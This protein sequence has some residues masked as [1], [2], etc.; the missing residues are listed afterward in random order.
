MRKNLLA[1]I[2]LLLTFIL[3]LFVFGELCVNM[4]VSYYI[5][6]S[7]DFLENGYVGIIILTIFCLLMVFISHKLLNVD[8]CENKW[9]KI[10]SILYLILFVA[11]VI[12]FVVVCVSGKFEQVYANAFQ[13][14]A[15]VVEM[16]CSVIISVL[17][18][19]IAV[20]NTKK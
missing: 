13:L 11:G 8:N 12:S 3:F 7:F 19:S 6:K 9:Y 2:S 14:F 17:Y 18:M 15:F 4:G 1:K 20:M 16:L 5:Y 10:D